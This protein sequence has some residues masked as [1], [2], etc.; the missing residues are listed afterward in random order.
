[1]YTECNNS[2]Y[3]EDPFCLIVS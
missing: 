2:V 1:M 3:H